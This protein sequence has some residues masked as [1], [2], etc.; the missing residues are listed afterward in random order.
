[1]KNSK[2]KKGRIAGIIEYNNRGNSYHEGGMVWL[3]LLHFE[4]QRIDFHC[5]SWFCFISG[6][7][8]LLL[9]Y[10]LLVIDN[11]ALDDQNQKVSIWRMTEQTFQQRHLV[12][13]VQLFQLFLCVCVCDCDY[14]D[15]FAALEE[16]L[17][18]FFIEQ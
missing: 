4:L 7:L 17:L 14:D 5:Y 12:V 10:L 6:Q 2:Q 1:M 8:S 11:N 13:D 18:L 3:I 15:T 9:N 16:T